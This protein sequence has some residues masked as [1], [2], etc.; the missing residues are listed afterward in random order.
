MRGAFADRLAE[1]EQRVA[2][3]LQT[4]VAWLDQIAAAVRNPGAA[5][6][7]AI[8]RAGYRLKLASRTIDA[9]LVR[10]TACQAPVASDLRLVLALVQLTHSEG[11][12]GNQFELISRELAEIDRDV[13]D[14]HGTSDR[15]S[16]M[17]SGAGL[18]LQHAAAAFAARDLALA[19]ELDREDDVLDRLNREVFEATLELEGAP[20]RRELGLRHVLIA[21][22][23]ERIGDNAVDVAEQA[24]FLVTA[25]LRE[26]TDASHPR[27]GRP[28]RPRQ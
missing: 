15:V 19:R 8:S 20:E 13:T 7:D 22:S 4:A 25:Q 12:I 11:L 16:R 26:F 18:Q 27:P 1:L 23:L 3:E 5:K 10:L 14:R 24:E 28:R 6:A 21:R 9:D 2:S 17:A